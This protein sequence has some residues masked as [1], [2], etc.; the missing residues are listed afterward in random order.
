[1]YVHVIKELIQSSVNYLK[2]VCAWGGGEIRQRDAVH[3]LQAEHKSDQIRSPQVRLKNEN[4]IHRTEEATE[5][6]SS[7]KIIIT[8]K[9]SAS[10]YS[11]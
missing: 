8:T 1:M 11:N 2:V 4:Y 5:I 9:R 7:T 6:Y 10:H 3:Q